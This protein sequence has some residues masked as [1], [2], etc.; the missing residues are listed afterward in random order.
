MFGRN[1]PAVGF[2]LDLKSLA[3]AAGATLAPAA[4][5]APWGE[6][7]QLRAA[8]RRL[9][10]A[11]EVVLAVLPG[12]EIESQAFSCDRELVDVGGRWVLRAIAAASAT[13]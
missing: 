1:R 3:E 8:V 4:I 9:R 13:T 7:A 2:S 11:G 10:D 5:R 6:D 12:H